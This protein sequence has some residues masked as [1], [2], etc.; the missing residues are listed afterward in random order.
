MR[1]ESSEIGASGPRRRVRRGEAR[2]SQLR[3]AALERLEERALMAVLP[4]PTSVGPVLV[5][6]TN[7]TT[8]NGVPNRRPAVFSELIA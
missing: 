1:W 8:S 4:T 6:S 5:S 7:S 3:K 2:K